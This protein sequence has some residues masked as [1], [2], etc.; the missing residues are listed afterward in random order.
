MQCSSLK[1]CAG[2]PIITTPMKAAEDAAQR[3]AITGRLAGLLFALGAVASAPANELFRDPPVRSAAHWVDL[4]AFV[5]GIV[6]L[7]IP[8]RRVPQRWFH[9]LPIA[10]TCEVA[11]SVWS[12]GV[13]G[14]IY[15]WYYGLVAVF[16]AYAFDRRGHIAAHMLFVA[17]A[18]AL[19]VLYLH[20]VT[21]A[22][23]RV[24]V[25]VPVL[26]AVAGVVAYLRE[27]LEEGKALLAQQARTDALTGIANLRMRDERLAYE[28]ARHRRVGRE[29]AVLVLDLDRFKEV[30][31]TEGHPAGDRLLRDVAAVLSSTVRS[32]DTVSRPGGDEF[33][34]IAPETS[35]GE[36]QRLAER[37][38]LALSTLS[39]AG[40]PLCASIGL[41]LF[42]HDGATAEQVIDRADLDQRM[43]KQAAGADRARFGAALYAV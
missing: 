22:A 24:A 27:G 40:R 6:C 32:G 2:L 30:N 1:R 5:S 37:I 7:S 17:V 34:V 13:H 8:W 16:T 10:G 43:V 11:L 28:I 21:D 25:A 18:F 26:F 35:R 36:A 29:L 3:R 23:I 31:D 12:V 9:L 39:A 41:A 14:G 15:A 4:L 38:E 33:C 42:P 20:H 19:P